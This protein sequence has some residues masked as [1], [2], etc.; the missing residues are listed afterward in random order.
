MKKNKKY[1]RLAGLVVLLALVIG[2]SIWLEESIPPVDLADS[3]HSVFSQNGE[4]GVIARIFQV[5]EPTSKF[6][7]EFG[8]G[9]GV[10]LSNVRNLIINHG[11]HGLLIEGD[12]KLSAKC[13]EVYKD[14]PDVTCL[15]KWVYPGNVET[16]F[17][18]H[19]VPKDVDFI[20]IDIDSFGYYVWK[21]MHLFRPKLV[22]IEVN[23]LFAPPIRAV[24][25]YSPFDYWDNSFYYG[26]S[27]QS[28]YELG[29]KKGYK[30][31]Y[32]EKRGINA[33]FVD[34]KYYDRFNI[35]DNSPAR[36]YHP[37]NY[38]YSITEKDLHKYID[39]DGHIVPGSKDPYFNSD[40]IVWKKITIQKH[41]IIGR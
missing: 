26:A 2:A 40:P 18:D 38:K 7:I 6:C 30:L 41:W 16:I 37:H 23:G 4:D 10:H 5:I 12:Q 24:V 20:V 36:L 19:H 11:W 27:L 1:F 32:M 8:A 22:Q 9:D 17:E 21:V 28:L 39:K 15:H 34:K 3:E 35:K 29:K 14:R 13:S 25:E 33:F 31:V